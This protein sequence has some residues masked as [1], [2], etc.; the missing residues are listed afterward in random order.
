MVNL[1]RTVQTSNELKIWNITMKKMGAA[2]AIAFLLLQTGPGMAAPR[3]PTT[4]MT[5]Q[6]LDVTKDQ[7]ISFRNFDGA[8]LIYFTGLVSWKCGLNQI[9]YSIN[10]ESLNKD[11][12]LPDCNP[13]MPFAS[14]PENDLLYLR[15][16]LG[17]AK[18]VS[19]QLI[20]GDESKSPMMTF[21]P[22]HV[23]GDETCAVPVKRGEE[24]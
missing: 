24:N 8:Q 18:T 13:Q 7:W 15:L 2:F 17:S 5:K 11:F 9:K 21:K 14:D 16:P 10:D 22:C 4:D 20:Y 12:P 1:V 6:A 3:K 19:V 23:E